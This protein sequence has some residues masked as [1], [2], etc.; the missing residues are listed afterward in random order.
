MLGLFRIDTKKKYTFSGYW[1]HHSLIREDLIQSIRSR[2]RP[3][4][5]SEALFIFNSL[6][7]ID[8]IPVACHVRGGDFE[9]LKSVSFLNEKYY[10]IAI[11]KSEELLGKKLKFFLFTD[12]LDKLGKIRPAFESKNYEIIST[13]D[14]HKD[15]LLMM[16]FK[17]FILSN[18]TFSLWASLLSV[19]SNKLIIRPTPMN[20][21]LVDGL[22]IGNEILIDKSSF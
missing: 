10:K 13:D 6:T 12:D 11:K 20:L 9:R 15:F 2:I 22:I 19:E 8:S 5:I 3:L 17:N 18:S 21:D 14:F 16:N 7:S 1:H 4:E